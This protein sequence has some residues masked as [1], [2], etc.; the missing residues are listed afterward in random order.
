MLLLLENNH[1]TSHHP[2][3]VY[4]PR[5]AHAIELYFLLS[6]CERLVYKALHK[7]ATKELKFAV[8]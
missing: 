2:L 7:V 3:V 1:I 5:K 4:F 8:L 6:K